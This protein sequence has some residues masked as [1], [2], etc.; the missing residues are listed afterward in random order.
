MQTLDVKL[1]GDALKYIRIND[2][3]TIHNNTPTQHI[4]KNFR[5]HV[6]TEANK[7]ADAFFIAGDLFDQ[8]ADP[9]S[10]E[11]LV[12]IELLSNILDYCYENN[13]ILRVLEGT[14]LHD[15]KQPKVMENLNA[16]RANKADFKYF[17][18]LDIEYIS[19]IGKYVLYIPDEWCNDHPTVERHIEAKM[20]ELNIHQVDI[21]IMHGQFTYQMANIPNPPFCYEESY[22]LKIVKELI[23]IGH[24]HIK[25]QHDRIH[26]GPSFDRLKHGEEDAKGYM[27][28]TGEHAEFIENP[29]AY[30]YNTY[31]L[32]KR[33]TLKSLDKKIL[34]LPDRSHVRLELTPDHPFNIGFRDLVL[35]Y[36]RYNLT[37]KVKDV[38]DSKPTTDIVSD[39]ADV[40]TDFSNLCVNMRETVYE[41]IVKENELSDTA[42][43]KLHKVLEVFE[44]TESKDDD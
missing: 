37:K 22:F 2:I 12:T 40:M 1:K 9:S 19:R 14:P 31:V 25:S 38:S 28:V 20:K 35:R 36:H 32:S 18:V 21:A 5:K 44:E 7:D 23:H 16:A 43:K 27:V 29:D 42:L 26:A 41:S 33:D 39:V 10:L 30:V 6:L 4:V 17:D 15:W 34:N 13:I 8:L 24:F 3:H 11:Y